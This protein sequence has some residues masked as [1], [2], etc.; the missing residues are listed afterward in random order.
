MYFKKS[1]YIWHG[2]VPETKANLGIPQELGIAVPIYS[3]LVRAAEVRLLRE[4]PTNS[5]DRSTIYPDRNCETIGIGDVNF[6]FDANGNVNVNG[7]C[8]QNVQVKVNLNVNFN[9]NYN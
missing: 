7:N 8:N 6:K 4:R 2:K 3:I 1:G 9:F 5:T